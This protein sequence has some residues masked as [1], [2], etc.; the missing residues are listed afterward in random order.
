MTYKDMSNY[1]TYV[2][3][4]WL[5]QTRFQAMLEDMV[6]VVKDESPDRE[7]TPA[8]STHERRVRTLAQD[9]EE[10]IWDSDDE[11]PHGGLAYDYVSRAISAVNW[12]EIAESVMED[13]NEGQ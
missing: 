3:R 4:V 11:F 2:T 13:F 9:L 8:L 1:E 7:N 10:W 6:D 5:S 12:H